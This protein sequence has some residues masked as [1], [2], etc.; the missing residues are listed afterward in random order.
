MA[1]PVLIGTSGWSYRH[2]RGPFYPEDLPSERWLAHYAQH[3]PTVEIDGTFYR[4]PDH[5]TFARWQQ[6]TPAHFRFALK[7]SRSITHFKKLKDSD[8]ALARLLERSAA[9]GDKRGPILF[10]LPPRWHA[11][12]MRLACFLRRL[13]PGPRYA[14]E[15]RHPSWFCEAV[16]DLLRAFECAF[17]IY[18]LGALESP[19]LRTAPFLYLRLHGPRAPYQGRYGR[20]ALQPWARRIRTWARQGHPVYCYFDNDAQAHAVADAQTLQ[21]LLTP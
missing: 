7:A 6:Q 12:P 11:D 18:Q 21:A 8:A 1:A 2:W 15:F 17:C 20:R 10:Q 14:F 5:A 3:F 9:L 19:V 16:Y 13:P 4:L